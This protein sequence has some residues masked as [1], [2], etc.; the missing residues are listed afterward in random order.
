MKNLF[1]FCFV[2][3]LY[4]VRT[5]IPTSIFPILESENIRYSRKSDKHQHEGKEKHWLSDSNYTSC[6]I[7]G[8]K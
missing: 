3:L 4:S 5:C 1:W 2:L 6:V 8:A 7:G